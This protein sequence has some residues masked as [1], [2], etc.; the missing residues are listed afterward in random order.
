MSEIFTIDTGNELVDVEANSPEEALKFV[1]SQGNKK[2]DVSS[3]KLATQQEPYKSLNEAS[4]LP[5][6]VGGG[7][8]LGLQKAMAPT[9][10]NPSS[11]MGPTQVDNPA[12]LVQSAMNPKET[13]GNVVEGVKQGVKAMAPGFVPAEEQKAAFDIGKTGATIM[14]M[15]IPG[16][17]AKLATRFQEIAPGM[18][19]IKP[20]EFSRYFSRQMLGYTGVLMKNKLARAQANLAAETA[21]QADLI[22]AGAST[23]TVFR[24]VGD[25]QKR[26]GNAIERLYSKA[27]EVG[28]FGID[29]VFDG[30]EALKKNI[31]KGRT[32][33]VWESVT[34]KI[35]D[36]QNNMIGLISSEEPVTL[37]S[38]KELKTRLKDSVNFMS[39]I[40]TQKDDKAILRTITKAMDNTFQ[41]VGGDLD[42]LK[43]AKKLY[44]A[45]SSGITGLNRRLM[46]GGNMPVSLPAI[47]AG[48]GADSAAQKIIE[49][50]L[51]E[52]IKR[53]GAGIIAKSS[54]SAQK[55]L[56]NIARTAGAGAITAGRLGLKEQN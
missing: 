2:D 53:R 44:Q 14:T 42:A 1:K 13:I 37:N 6:R 43:V 29:T 35:E 3:F 8:A 56:P 38:I 26:A 5:E 36:A 23:E 55:N 33:S 9:G 32:G 11:L 41:A 19:D 17:D 22:P 48:A 39:D 30:L 40:A 46:Q 16:T 4:Q 20:N 7:A 18:V 49:I 25:L 28:T 34:K 24:R 47:M 45:A 54:F 10:V 15:V 31:V 12:A 27:G 21:L 50:G 52:G 51:T